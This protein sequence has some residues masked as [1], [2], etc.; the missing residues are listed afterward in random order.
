MVDQVI[1]DTFA[2]IYNDDFNDSAGFHRVLFNNGR[3]I[4][5]RELT[6]LQ[7]IIQKE[8][9][10]FG[11]NI[12]KEG[13]AVSAAGVNSKG[14][15]YIK[16]DESTNTLA[17]HAESA[18]LNTTFT[19]ATSGVTANVYH[20]VPAENS[21]PAT[22]YIQYISSDGA[23][24]RFTPGEDISNGSVTLTIQTTN[25]I[26]NPATGNG[27]FISCGQGEFYVGGRFVFAPA[28]KVLASKYTSTLT[29]DIGFKIIE[30]IITAQDD[31]SLYDNSGD[32]PN[33][34]SPGADR[35][36]I[37]LELTVRSTI[38]SSDNFVYVAKLSNGIII[39]TQRSTN[40]EN[41]NVIGEMIAKR[42]YEESGDY[43]INPFKLYFS[44][45]TNDTSK[46][47]ITLNTGLA[48]V[49]G[50][51][52]SKKIPEILSVNKPRTT[53]T[54]N[55]EVSS[56]TLGNYIVVDGSN[57][58]GLPSI[59]NFAEV[60]LR[61][62]TNYGGATI[63]TARVRAINE[64]GDGNYRLHLFQITM[65]SGQ[66]FRSVRSIG[67]G[68]SDYMNAVLE[69]GQCVIK[70]SKSNSLLFTLPRGRPQ[71]FTDISLSTQRKFTTS[72]TAGT[73]SLTLSA[74]GETFANTND[75]VI[76]LDDSDVFTGA[77]ISGV[78]TASSSV[79]GLG[80]ASS[81]EIVTYVNKAN[82]TIRSKTLNEDQVDTIAPG[83][84]DSDGTGFIYANLVKPDIYSFT[85]V[86]KDTVGGTSV[87]GR[88][89]LDNG[90]RDNY[91]GL[92]RLVLKSGQ[93][94][95]TY[96]VV[97]KYDYFS[98]G[99][100]GD[101]FAVNSY[102]G[103]VDYEN[104]PSHTL[105][106]GNILSLRDVI[107]FRPVVNSLGTFSAGAIVNELPQPFDTVQADIS[108]YNYSKNKLVVDTNGNFSFIYGKE[109]LDPQF[110]ATPQRSLELYRISM[111]PYT[112]NAQDIVSKQIEH[113]HYTMADIGR[114]EKK[115]NK[116]Q[117]TTTLNLLELDTANLSVLDSD[118][119]NRTKSGF[120]VDN[121]ANH[122][123][124]DITDPNYSAA[125]DPAGKSLRSKNSTDAINLEY[126]SDGSSGVIKKGDNIY[127]QYAHREYINQDLAS[128]TESLNPLIEIRFN[129]NILLSPASD[130]WITQDYV[131]NNIISGGTELDTSSAF[132][133][134]DHEWNWNGVAI[135]QLSV[136]SQTE[137]VV[138]NSS[139]SSGGTSSTSSTSGRTT[140]TNTWQDW[141][142]TTTFGS[143]TI[144]G[145]STVTEII[146]DRLLQSVSIP[147][148]RSRKV[149][150]KGEGFRPDT[151]LYAFFDNIDV[152]DWCRKETFV[153]T[154][155]DAET[156]GN[157]NNGA[158]GHPEGSN[159]LLVDADGSIEGSFFIP[160]TSNLRFS[161]GTKT[162]QLIDITNFEEDDATSFG[163]SVYTSA[164][165]IET[166]QRDVLSTRVLEVTSDT[167]S[168][169][170]SARTLVSSSSFTRPPP[171]PPAPP[172]VIPVAPTPVPVTPA[173]PT[174]PVPPA[175]P[176]R[177]WRENG[178]SEGAGSK[179]P[180]AQ[181]FFVTPSN[182]VFVTKL[183][184]YFSA[185]HDSLPMWIQL[186]PMA[187]GSPSYD[188]IPG[189]VIYKYPSE[190]D[191]SDDASLATTFEFDE[192]I[193]LS[194]GKE[195][196]IV[197][198]A[199]VTDYRIWT[200]RVGDFVLGTTDAKITKQP[201]LGS[202]FKSQ[203][204][205][206][207][208][209]TQWEDMKF[210]LHTAQ[211]TTNSGVA[212]LEN[213]DVPQQLLSSDPLSVADSDATISV[214][215]PAHG[216][217]VGDTVNISGAVELGGI[218]ASSINGARTI[219][220]RDAEYYT[221]EADS[222]STSSEIGGGDA[223]LADQNMLMDVANL[224]MQT[225][226][227]TTTNIS[228]SALTTSGQSIAGT[229]T[230]Y[231]KSETLVPFNVGSNN[232]FS[233]PKLIANAS[234]ETS[235]MGG[236]KSFSLAVS[237]STGDENVSPVIDMQRATLITVSN[238]IDKQSASPA[239]GFNVPIN[240]VSETNPT[241]GSSAAKHITKVTTL[242]QDAVG[243]KVF[244][245]ANKPSLAS[246]EVYYRVSSGD[247][248]IKEQEWT[249]VNPESALISDENPNTFREYTYLVGGSTGTLDAF[250]QM[251]L[252]VVMLSEN[253][254]KPPVF[255]D[256]RAI[257]LSV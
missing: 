54:V 216:F 61:S 206:T 31:I 43:V 233:S 30:S 187:D 121:F 205:R 182:G 68:A 161:A 191:V 158:M 257:A 220:A 41:Y 57:G 195:Y 236:R 104:I 128:T 11:N 105:A 252:K 52:V 35:Y 116:L 112:L 49:N 196:A 125:I 207:W 255:R 24:T 100:S 111:N 136:G 77:S 151:R 164:G 64:E 10:R 18:Y 23:T 87:I 44:N 107:D 137:N 251:Q 126:D 180:L 25:T 66:N 58:A 127:L 20:V 71:N 238:Q 55:N 227:P 103:Q 13:A 14:A 181:S 84:W 124:S 139:T 33:T 228:A 82:A 159:D 210:V 15:N 60:N 5:A 246:F 202:L 120:F 176:V 118:G 140:T 144:T 253:S 130:N 99:V 17:A 230:A 150:F 114:L 83:D 183:D 42:T 178:G 106:N 245:S 69:L 19:G 39:D 90:Q 208:T 188:I 122:F 72:V 148:I 239:A 184:L 254:A 244:V 247:E 16:L 201:F 117:E 21:D 165:V 59:S 51:R 4:Q 222:A 249:L 162:F 65:N 26:S 89:S 157:T 229:E 200:S 189:S 147:F 93:S 177:T 50:F 193:Y 22:I 78:G 167:N 231:Q 163:G 40:E 81:A 85:S 45:N 92:G 250:N 108:Y 166:R 1:K 102:S 131:A 88:F 185:K 203:N 133:W 7:T 37:E 9:T 224:N 94:V 226:M 141:S 129:G 209:P 149:Y 138:L 32:L 153:R 62:S 28:Q 240:F 123:F 170:V 234:N 115:V 248:L 36:K 174:P 29:D 213:T 225:I 98:H 175:P 8:I 186:R 75:W 211:F 243:L 194:P 80:S 74:S 96:D 132:L 135:D 190:I 155:D 199:S 143:N 242:A 46:L 237:M 86:T 219:T 12:F 27:L 214:Y 172:V 212:L 56:F 134:N 256:L 235:Q 47:D 110:P 34:S 192:P 215:Q 119:N 2:G 221:F 67:T 6:Q 198:L 63:G 204:S 79:S 156:V 173:P 101:F 53:T 217:T 95:P 152:T 160:S 197:A 218:S 97:V 168:E 241:G 3:A 223:V 109:A 171:P 38:E 48:Y 154:S 70:N 113:K 179:D 73:A 76:S 142:T 146:G 91:Y 232:F 169:T 145:E